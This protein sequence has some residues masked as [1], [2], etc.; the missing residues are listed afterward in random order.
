MLFVGKGGPYMMVCYDRVLDQGFS[1]DDAVQHCNL[2]VLWKVSLAFDLVAFIKSKNY[3]WYWPYLL[4]N[5]NTL[6]IISIT[7]S[8]LVYTASQKKKSVI[9]KG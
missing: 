6:Y 3:P 7:A 5:M 1:A 9:L 4:H 8:D 2:V